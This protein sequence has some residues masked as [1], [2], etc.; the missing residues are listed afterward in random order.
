[1]RE[2]L[3]P[4]VDTY[5]ALA[6]CSTPTLFLAPG[7]ARKDGWLFMNKVSILVDGEIA[8]EREFE[9]ERDNGSG[10]VFE[11]GNVPISQRRS[12]ELA[13]I[14]K[15][16]TSQSVIVRLTGSKGYLTLE[17]GAVQ[18]MQQNLQ[19]ALRSFDA[20]DAAVKPVSGDEC[21]P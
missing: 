18:E 5:L 20:I 11:N 19:L 2:T 6:D 14:R 13:G 15:A 21:A 17:R 4:R 1:M 10:Y 7:F 3:E 16:A 8:F 12:T 9:A